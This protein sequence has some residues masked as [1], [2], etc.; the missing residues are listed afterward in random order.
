MCKHLSSK[1]VNHLA[2]WAA[3]KHQ[4]CNAGLEAGE[5][6]TLIDLFFIDL[7]FID[8]FFIELFFIN[9]GVF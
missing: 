3:G 1:G 4:V 5:D 7:L 2:L 6:L 8:L 9:V